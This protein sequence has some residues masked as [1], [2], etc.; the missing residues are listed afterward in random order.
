VGLAE[1]KDYLRIGYDGEDDLVARLIA[2]ARA[3]VEAAC[4][5]ALISRTLRV[6]LRRWS[7]G[8]VET[9]VTRMPVRPA[10]ALIAVRVFDVEGVGEDVTGCFSLE[11]GRSAR[12][13]WTGG[14]HPWPGRRTGG[15]EIDYVAGFGSD[16]D[17]VAAELRL[18][19]KR[20]AAHAYHARDA[21]TLA[22]AL[23]G[24]VAGLL[25]AWRRVSL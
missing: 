15:I 25:A 18:A 21:E 1:A 3:R 7:P 8:P 6:A 19:V 10:K 23:P 5:I 4:G 11:T 20:L 2:G 24:D 13:V 17:D 9:R 14:S 22:G 16:A 12:L